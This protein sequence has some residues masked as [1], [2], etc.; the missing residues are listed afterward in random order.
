MENYLREDSRNQL[1]SKS[2]QSNDGGQA[3]FKR[4]LKSKVAASVKD[5]NSIDMN[6]LFKEDILNV[7]ISVQ[8]ETD[9]YTVKLS[10]GGI[11]DSLHTELNRNNNMLTLRLVMR[12]LVTAFNRDNVFISCS[13]P[14][15]RYRYGFWA[16][17]NNINSGEAEVRP[18]DITNPNDTKGS[19]CKHVLLVLSNTSWLIKVASVIFN[20][21]NYMEKHYANT[22]QKVIYPAVYGEEYDQQQ[23]DMPDEPDELETDTDTLDKSNKYA[24]AKTRFQPRNEYRFR[25]NSKVGKQ[26]SFDDLISDT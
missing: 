18:S 15:F 17:K 14:D 16:T 25:P 22:Y 8:G 11:L 12:A 9:K 2:K 3:R 23:L 20:Y 4:R 10:F 24:K 1:L 5:Y 19:A 6:K 13:C 26:I 7:N 21:I